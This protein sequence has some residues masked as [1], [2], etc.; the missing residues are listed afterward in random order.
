MEVDT[1]VRIGGH[2]KICPTSILMLKADNNYTYIYFIDG[3]FVLSS[4]NL[5]ILEKRLKECNFFR[6]HRSTIINLQYVSN[7]EGKDII[8]H[9]PIIRLTNGTKNPLSRRKVAVFLKIIQ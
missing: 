5:G 3:S 9:F 2:K 1:F 6:S 4:T 7:F 8:R